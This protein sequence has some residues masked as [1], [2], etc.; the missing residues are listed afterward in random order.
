MGEE[1]RDYTC[2]VCL[3]LVPMRWEHH[4]PTMPI[5]PLCRWCEGEYARGVGK[6]TGGSFRDRR[7]VAR[8]FAL[9]EALRCEAASLEWRSKYAAA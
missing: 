8:G 1:S 7:E 6:P 3:R 2:A 4:K 9:A 5:W